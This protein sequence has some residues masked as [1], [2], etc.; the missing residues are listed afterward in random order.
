MYKF[1]IIISLLN[2]LLLLCEVQGLSV[3]LASKYL[4]LLLK[5]LFR[6]MLRNVDL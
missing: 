3:M 5:I 4:T 1:N 2:L 6:T